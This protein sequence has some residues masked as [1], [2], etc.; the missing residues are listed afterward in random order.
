M[1]NTFSRQ[2][3]AGIC[4]SIFN[5]LL[6]SSSAVLAMPAAPFPFNETQPDGQEITL[7]TRGDENYN[8]MEDADGYTV[9]KNKGWFEYAEQAPSGHLNPNG[10]VVGRSNPKAAGLEKHI[11]PTAAIR[12]LSAKKVDGASVTSEGVSAQ[13]V[14]PAGTVKN[15]VVMLRFS[16]HV[17]R[18]LPSVA[19]VDVLFN[20]T[21]GHPTLAPTGSVK[22]V[23]FENSYG[24]MT[25]NSFV[26]PLIGN[27]ITV[28]NTEAYYANGESGDETLWLA[29][30]EALTALDNAGVNFKDY[31]TDNDGRI[32]S[33]AFIHSGYGAEWGGSDAYGT[34]QASRIWSH[35]W[36]IQP[37]WNS[38]DGVSV[39]DYHISPGVWG[40]SGSAIGRIG[41][42]AH[43]TGH[44]FGLPDLY[45]T[46]STAGEGVGSWELMANSW[47]F[48]YTQLCPPHFSP[49]SKTFLGWYTPTVISQPGQYTINQ[50]E[51]NAQAY[52]INSGFSSGEY[53][54]IENRQDTGFDCTIPQGG[55]A[56]WHIDDNVGYNTQGYPGQSNW[57][58]NGLHYRVAL[59]QADGLYNLEKGNNRGDSGDM[60]H[61]AGVDAI[62]PGPGNHPNTDTY[63]GGVVTQTGITIS[64]ISASSASMTFCLN[65]C[66]GV[67]AP[68]GLTA[69]AQSTSQIALNWADNSSAETGFTIDRSTNGTTWSFLATVSA[70]VTS[71]NNSGLSPNATWFYRVSAFAGADTSTWS[72]TA[73]ATTFD[74]P[75][76]APAS[77]SATPASSSQINLAWADSANNETGYRVEQSLNGGGTWST[78]ATL[79]AN[80][81]GYNNTGLAAN[82]IYHYRVAAFN[83]AGDSG[84]ATANA[85]TN[86]PPPYF[87]Y[88]AQSQTASEGTVSG[89]YTNTQGDDGT[90]QS[91]TEVQTGGNPSKRRSSLSHRW[92]FNVSAGNATTL[93]ANAWKNADSTDGDNFQFQYSTDGA[94]YTNAFLVSSILNSN[95]QSFVL[96]NTLSGTVYV[97]VI[98][99]NDVQGNSAVDTLS[100]DYLVIHVDN[101]VVTPPAAPTLQSATAVAYNQ[102]NLVWT[103]NASDETAYEVQRATGGGSYSTVATLGANVVSYSDASVSAS[104]AYNYK[105]RA[106]KGATPSSDSNVL[107]V[108]TP[109]QPSGSINLSAS[110]FK[111]KGVQQV[112]LSWS[113]AASGNVDIKRTG[114]SA[115][116][117]T[118]PNSGSYNDN[119]GIKGTATYQYEVCIAGTT[120][121]SNKAT[122]VF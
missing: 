73:S 47:D 32:D 88:V 50:A 121:C 26:N 112:D 7:R 82:T 11:K 83:S 122:V 67:P 43:E 39:Y 34:P 65:G 96:P 98:D 3:R 97:R 77:M 115:K 17:G 18:T 76:V 13:G 117:V 106:L 10:M 72:N 30:K 90:V 37:Q 12:A 49:W 58:A 62:G 87:D 44:F 95:Q 56:I 60:H 74:V 31:D 84:F 48:N 81:I 59:L 107:P 9:V 5:F 38:N 42:I 46:D 80:S 6:F 71:Y 85:T 61:A 23:Y 99:T 51:T 8:W 24:Q 4:L 27:W 94:S 113:P 108:T 110:G 40:T 68:S 1:S 20:A 28:S 19:D 119:I 102:V 100:V 109:A 33:I 70:N 91:I 35:R 89:S 53:L 29:L 101:T 36:A 52:R 118:V 57:P 104:T 105:V 64:S 25:L 111:V 69:T 2:L 86:P 22:D 63:K 45:D 75:P 16:N 66:T 54:L 21:G 79:G 116:T 55:I 92:T 103:D 114:S 15:L 93:M 41:V 78:I 120:T 14:A